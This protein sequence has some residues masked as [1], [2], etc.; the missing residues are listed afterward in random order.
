[1]IQT[2]DY[3]ASHEE[4]DWAGSRAKASLLLHIRRITGSIE[5]NYCNY[6]K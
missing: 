4:D 2:L 6:I 1:M 5:N 3:G